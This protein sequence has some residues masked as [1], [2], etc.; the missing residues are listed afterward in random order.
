MSTTGFL[1]NEE[2]ANAD[3]DVLLT[4]GTGESWWFEEIWV[5]GVN[6]NQ[7]GA[8][9]K[10]EYV[11]DSSIMSSHKMDAL[12]VELSTTHKHFISRNQQTAGNGFILRGLPDLCVPD[13]LRLRLQED[14]LTTGDFTIVHAI[15]AVIDSTDE[16]SH[17]EKWANL[18]PDTILQPAT[19]QMIRWEMWFISGSDAGVGL[20]VTLR[21]TTSNEPII[22]YTFIFEPDPA[23]TDE[24]E[25]FK[26]ADGVTAIPANIMPMFIPKGYEVLLAENMNAGDLAAILFVGREYSTL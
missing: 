6:D 15:G 8:T 11:S 2:M 21:K 14:I 4:P 9:V 24:Y 17:A 7:T 10:T 3:P 25:V 13:G 26:D 1:I 19:D 18:D 22:A 12:G 20:N 23:N 5:A 16:V